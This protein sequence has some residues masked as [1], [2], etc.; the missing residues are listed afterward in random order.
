LIILAGRPGI[1]KT[2][3]ALQYLLHNAERGVPG[4]FFTLEMAPEK[5]AIR[6]WQ[7]LAG[8]KFERDMSHLTPAQKAEQLRHLDHVTNDLP[9]ELY[10]K[11]ATIGQIAGKIRRRYYEAGIRFAVIDYL[12]LMESDTTMHQTVREQEVARF[13]RA[14][15]N[16]TRELKIPIV[17]LSQLSR[18]VEKQGG[19]KKP[20][21]AD[22]RESG[23]LEQDADVIALLWQAAAYGITED[24]DGLLPPEYAEVNIA[25]GREYGQ[26]VIQCRFNHLKGFYDE[27]PAW[28]DAQFPTA[29]PPA[30]QH[31]K[32]MG[33]VSASN[34]ARKPEQ[35]LPF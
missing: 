14:M 17:A 3:L 6:L 32:G 34:I 18:E 33:I 24:G 21:V 10:S 7:K 12:Q 30:M 35:D 2:E 8:Q 23:S 5:L 15:K 25:K 26:A 31:T 27:V 28:K 16:L 9:I 11:D 20:I 13:S 19:L 1:G 29:E 22:L 4:E